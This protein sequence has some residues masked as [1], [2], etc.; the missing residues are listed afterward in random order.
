MKLSKDSLVAVVET[1]EVAKS[2]FGIAAQQTNFQAVAAT[3]TSHLFVA[4]FAGELDELIATHSAL[5][6]AGES[7]TIDV[8]KNGVSVLVGAVPYS[9]PAVGGAKVGVMNLDPNLKSF[10]VG[11]VFQTVR[12]YVVGA[13]TPIANSTVIARPTLQGL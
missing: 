9:V 12:T 5:G 3:L 2:K 6:G 13:A 1:P 11:D 4:E 8:Q 7:L 10:V